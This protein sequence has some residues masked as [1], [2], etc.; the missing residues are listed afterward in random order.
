LRQVGSHTGTTEGLSQ[1]GKV[2]VPYP[3]HYR[4]MRG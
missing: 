3:V 2:H 1:F 4:V